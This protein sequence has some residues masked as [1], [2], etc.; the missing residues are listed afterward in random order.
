MRWL[1]AM[2]N[3]YQQSVGALCASV[4]AAILV[5]LIAPFAWAQ[6]QARAQTT[7]PSPLLV[8][9]SADDFRKVMPSAPTVAPATGNVRPVTQQTPPDDEDE[10]C[11]EGHV[12]RGPGPM[13]TNS[14]SVD[15]VIPFEFD[16]DRLSPEAVAILQNLATVLREERM[17]FVKSLDVVGHS[18]GVGDAAYNKALSQRRAQSVRTVLEKLQL[19]GLRLRVYGYGME[20]LRNTVDPKSAENRRVEFVVR[21]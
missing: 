16:S 2:K 8:N 7:K 10:P 4:V 13:E 15:V 20:R 11:P 3:Q 21:Y 19:L 6:V 17:R 9:P 1:T 5:L 12:C 14:R 18:D